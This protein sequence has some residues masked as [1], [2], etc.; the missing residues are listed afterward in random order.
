MRSNCS[1]PPW[2]IGHCDAGHWQ[3]RNNQLSSFPYESDS[4][5]VL[6]WAVLQPL[7]HLLFC[8]LLKNK[9][10]NLYKAFMQ[11][12]C[13]QAGYRKV[14]QVPG[15]SSLLLERAWSPGQELFILQ[16]EGLISPLCSDL[17][18]RSYGS[19][20]F[21]C[22][23]LCPTWPPLSLFQWLLAEPGNLHPL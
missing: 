3:V 12:P 4:A 20:L 13:D 6:V 18:L 9:V 19:E 8:F 1:F 10:Y 7:P 15:C 23:W 22:H 11:S 16:A 2:G 5:P 21:P 14:I 17:I